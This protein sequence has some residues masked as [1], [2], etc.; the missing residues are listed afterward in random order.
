MK[1]YGIW[2]IQLLIIFGI[3][4]V[5]QQYIDSQFI[6]IVIAVVVGILGIVARAVIVHNQADILE[7]L[8]DVDKHMKSI[9]RYKDKEKQQNTYQ[10]LLAYG[11]TYSNKL[12]SAQDALNKVDYE[13]IK[14]NRHLHYAYF[15]TKLNLLYNNKDIMGYKE[16]LEKANM[17]NVFRVVDIPK[18]AFEVQL[19]I[20]ESKHQKA[21]DLAKE[22]I[23]KVRKR[24]LI[25][26]LE[27]LLAL[28][29]KNLNHKEDALAVADFMWNKNYNVKYTQ[30]C[31]D[32]ARDLKK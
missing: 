6:I 11:Y 21:I 20:L 13:E 5:L 16:T 12:L 14:H 19:L 29:Y 4:Y 26:E 27:Y 9:E 1:Q 31:K 28:A 10:L 17:Y 30:F 23:P 2:M 18:E 3:Y 24:L 22:V 15:A 7:V 25:V 32:L 8:V